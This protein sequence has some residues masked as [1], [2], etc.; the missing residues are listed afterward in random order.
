MQ[1]GKPVISYQDDQII[2]RVSVQSDSGENQLWYSLDKKFG[3]LVSDSSDAALTAMLI[4]AMLSGEDIHLAGIVSEKLFHNYTR[5]YQYILKAIFPRLHQINIHPGGLH[6]GKSDAAGVATAVTAG[7]DSFCVLADHHYTSDIEDG[8]RVTHLLFNNT[9]SHGAGGERLFKERLT[10]I[11]PLATRI[12]LPLI[13]VN[14]NQDSYYLKSGFQQ[15]DIHT[16]KDMAVAH[17]LQNGIG[18]FLYA[19]SYPVTDTGIGFDIG[20]ID[21]CDSVVLPLMSTESV[22][23]ISACGE[24]SRVAK[25]VRILKIPDTYDTLE[26][27]IKAKD[28]KELGKPNCSRCMKC[29]KTLLTLEIAGHLDTY[30]SQFCLETYRKHRTRFISESLVNRK[31]GVSEYTADILDFANASGYTLPLRARFSASTGLVKLYPVSDLAV[32]AMNK[33][34]RT[35]F[36]NGIRI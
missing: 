9:G 35:V 1:I 28:A 3:G 16:H 21:R 36:N 5:Q 27:C 6:T 17:L 2:Y 10:R 18:R 33:I 19:S 20:G 13:T 24:Y 25:T 11:L 34:K 31:P 4:P 14:S 22:E 29:L 23:A 30:S 26:V 7:V 12:G 32:R 15:E 8:Y